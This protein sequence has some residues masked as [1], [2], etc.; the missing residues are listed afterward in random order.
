MEGL[1]NSI[2]VVYIYIYRVFGGSSKPPKQ[3]STGY[4]RVW[5]FGAYIR[6]EVYVWSSWVAVWGT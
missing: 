4:V 5:G 3:G 2:M 1:G 6:L